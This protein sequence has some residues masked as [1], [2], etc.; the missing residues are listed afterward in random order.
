M[1]SYRIWKLLFCAF[2]LDFC[3]I[4]RIMLLRSID[5]VLHMFRINS[6]LSINSLT[7]MMIFWSFS[8]FFGVSFVYIQCGLGCLVFGLVYSQEPLFVELFWFLRRFLDCSIY[9]SLCETL[10]MIFS[11]WISFRILQLRRLWLLELSL[12][13]LMR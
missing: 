6:L 9:Y 8:G 2:F 11:C 5:V 1:F 12:F 4:R 3:L 7:V 10:W 13:F